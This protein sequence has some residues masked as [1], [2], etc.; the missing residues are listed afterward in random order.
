MEMTMLL[1]SN[2]PAGAHGTVHS[3]PWPPAWVR[4][5]LQGCA[6]PDCRHSRRCGWECSCADRHPPQPSPGLR[7]PMLPGLMRIL[8]TAT[9]AQARA[10]PCSQ[11]DVCHNGDVH[12]ILDGFDALC[13]RRAGAGHAQDL[14]ASSFAPRCL[15]HIALNI[16]TGTLS[17]V[18]TATGFLRRWSHCRFSLPVLTAA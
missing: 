8:S 15:R 2:F 18:C 11:M 9:S 4:R 14:T 5:I 13:I 12:R 3:P 16:S 6:F 17:I 7:P 10:P 1:K